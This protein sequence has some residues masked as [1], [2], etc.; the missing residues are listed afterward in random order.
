MSLVILNKSGINTLLY[1]KN[2]VRTSR[3][4]IDKKSE[5]A[6]KNP[7]F[8]IN[9]TTVKFKNSQNC[10]V[11]SLFKNN[12]RTNGGSRKS[13]FVFIMPRMGLFRN[14][15]PNVNYDLKSEII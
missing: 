6:R 15:S 14:L 3:L 7:S 13:V 4:K 8:R 9:D 2:F 5:Q 10:H 1:Q 11:F 12:L